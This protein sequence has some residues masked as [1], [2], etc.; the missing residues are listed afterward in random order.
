MV[1]H[2]TGYK[3]EQTKSVAAKILAAVYVGGAY[4][5]ILV[6]LVQ[7]VILVSWLRH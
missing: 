4:G 2:Q 6:S 5:L 1:R 3:V 7:A